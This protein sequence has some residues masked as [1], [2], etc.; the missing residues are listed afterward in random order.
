MFSARLSRLRAFCAYAIIIGIFGG[1]IPVGTMLKKDKKEKKGIKEDSSVKSILITALIML[2]FSVGLSLSMSISMESAYRKEISDDFQEHHAMSEIIL[3]RYYSRES[4]VARNA[5]HLLSTHA[6][7]YTIDDVLEL[8][9]H[10]SAVDEMRH[11]GYV[12]G[13]GFIYL[14]GERYYPE[15]HENLFEYFKAYNIKENE[16]MVTEAGALISCI[17]SSDVVA[18]APVHIKGKMYHLDVTS[19]YPSLMIVYG[20]FTRNAKKPWKFKEVYD[21]RVALKKA[22]KKTYIQ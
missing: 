2:L 13:D 22:G 7:M 14:D 18:I 11:I 1:I 12:G 21:L 9:E 6:S 4:G 8:E 5:A 15:V 20:L 10:F 3:G 16:T 17:D 19:F